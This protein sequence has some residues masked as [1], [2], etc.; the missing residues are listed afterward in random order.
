MPRLRVCAEPGCPVLSPNSRCAEHER[1]QSRAR[2]RTAARDYGAKHQRQRRDIER[3][4]IE[5]YRCAKCGEQFEPGEPF[6]LGHTNDR[7]A[8]SGPEHVRCNLGAA[9][10]A[11]HA[12]FDRADGRRDGAVRARAEGVGGTP[13]R[14]SPD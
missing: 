13:G 14:P 1:E 7:R 10:R 4:G 2:G 5:N 9:G 11:A 12:V 3:R 6:H 8:W